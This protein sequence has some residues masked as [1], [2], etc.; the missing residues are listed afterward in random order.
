[1]VNAPAEP[2]M[3][4]ERRKSRALTFTLKHLGTLGAQIMC[5]SLYKGIQRHLQA[6]YLNVFEYK[7]FNNDVNILLFN[8][9]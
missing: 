1:M 3:V 2:L 9:N 7:R 5:L 6:K 4:T 8:C